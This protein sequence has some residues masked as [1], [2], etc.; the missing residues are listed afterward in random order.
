MIIIRVELWSAVTGQK[1]ELARMAICNESGGGNL[2]DYSGKTY[3]GR[4]EEALTRSM[5]NDT[6]TKR[7]EVLGHPAL[8]QHIWNL[9]AKM[10]T[11]M[12]Y[13]Q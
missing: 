11:N 3:R 2:R 4:D 7:G 5:V 1:T 10:L 9:V 12:G 13:G 8:K 6:V